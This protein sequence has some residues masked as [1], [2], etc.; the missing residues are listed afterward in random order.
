[1]SVSLI[2]SGFGEECEMIVSAA[3]ATGAGRRRRVAAEICDIRAKQD[4]ARGKKWAGE[5]REPES[6]GSLKFSLLNIGFDCCNSV[7]LLRID[8]SSGSA[9]AR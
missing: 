3:L 2:K 1:M 4:A 5:R 7:R 9:V 6:E 8:D